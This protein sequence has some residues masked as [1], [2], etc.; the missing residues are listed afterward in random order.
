[1]TNVW[2]DVINKGVL[3]GSLDERT[4][5]EVKSWGCEHHKIGE[6]DNC[7]PIMQNPSEDMSG[8]SGFNKTSKQLQNE[9][10]APDPPDPK[11]DFVQVT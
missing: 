3:R 11:P 6:N 1:M 4:V 7:H 8:P 9:N 10:E 2:V 5:P